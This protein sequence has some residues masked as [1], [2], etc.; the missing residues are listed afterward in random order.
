MSE[1]TRSIDESLQIVMP[2][3]GAT[4]AGTAMSR[5]ADQVPLVSPYGHQDLLSEIS[6]T[7]DSTLVRMYCK[8]RFLIININI[9][10]ILALCLRG[11]RRVL[12]IGCGFGL[13][14]CVFFFFFS[15]SFFF[16]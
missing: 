2:G 3:N 13:F 16:L 9:L 8:A 12:D 14:C 11:K 5:S 6:A 4:S 15:F 10:H 7:Y 1:L